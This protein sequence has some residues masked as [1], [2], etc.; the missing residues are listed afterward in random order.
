MDEN[1]QILRIAISYAKE[2]LS[3]KVTPAHLLK[4]LLHKDT[5]LI[6]LIEKINKD[7]YYILEWT[8][9]QISHSPKSTKIFKAPLVSEKTEAVIREAKN[10]QIKY[11]Y[12]ELDPILY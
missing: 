10:Y 11:D 5:G 6:G 4:A 9:V 2:T 3:E 8:E 1:N 12:P 7:Y